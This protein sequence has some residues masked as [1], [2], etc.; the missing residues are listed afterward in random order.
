MLLLDPFLVYYDDASLC[1][2][3]GT[4]LVSNEIIIVSNA[5]VRFIN[6]SL[7]GRWGELNYWRHNNDRR[8]LNCFRPKS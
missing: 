1:V 7:V 2:Q 4:V 5:A 6:N 8:E 3:L